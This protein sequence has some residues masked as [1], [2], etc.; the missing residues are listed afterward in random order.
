MSAQQIEADAMPLY[1]VYICHSVS[2]RAQL[3]KYWASIGP[4]L[5][6]HSVKFLAGYTP[7]E[8]LEGE[9]VLGVF[10]AEWPSMEAAKAWYDS[11]G[12]KAIHHLRMDNAKYTGVLVGSGLTPPEERLRNRIR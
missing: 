11:P 7:F 9:H 12:Y 3:E 8:V 2:D 10:V 4:T 1:M 6:G 5:E